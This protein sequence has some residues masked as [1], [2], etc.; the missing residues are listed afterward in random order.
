LSADKMRSSAS[1]SLPQMY[2]SIVVGTVFC[3]KAGPAKRTVP[4]IVSAASI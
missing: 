4:L 1:F 2:W 3:W